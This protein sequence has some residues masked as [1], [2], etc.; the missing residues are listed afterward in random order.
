MELTQ[1]QRNLK[2]LQESIEKLDQSGLEPEQKQQMIALLYHVFIGSNVSLEAF[3]SSLH[4][5]NLYHA[6]WQKVYMEKLKG[7]F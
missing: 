2:R 7:D 6:K 3:E 4:W 5:L 1:E